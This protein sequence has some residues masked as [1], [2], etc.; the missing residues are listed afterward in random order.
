[1]QVDI[2]QALRD[3]LVLEVGIDDNET[4]T[5]LLYGG[6]FNPV[7]LTPDDLLACFRGAAEYFESQPEMLDDLGSRLSAVLPADDPTSF[8]ELKL[9]RDPLVQIS[10]EAIQKIAASGNPY[11]SQVTKRLQR[12][13]DCLGRIAELQ[14]GDEEMFRVQRS[15]TFH[16]QGPLKDVEQ[17]VAELQAFGR[18]REATSLNDLVTS[19]GVGVEECPEGHVVILEDGEAIHTNVAVTTEIR[20]ALGDKLQTR[21]SEMLC[22]DSVQQEESEE[23]AAPAESSS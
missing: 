6:T 5:L 22:P 11:A 2:G 18:R 21:T 7:P 10:E 14:E 1:M 19:K 4:E 3:G 8:M 23:T 20:E 17:L 9:I 15:F 12:L 16:I 13:I